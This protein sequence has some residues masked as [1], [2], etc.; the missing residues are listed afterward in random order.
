MFYKKYF[1]EPEPCNKKNDAENEGKD[2]LANRNH[3]IFNRKLENGDQFFKLNALHNIPLQTTY[4]GLLI[5]SGYTHEF[6]FHE[7]EDKKEAFKIGFFFDHITGLP[8][9]PGHSVKGVLRS[10]FPNHEKEKY[11]K[12]KSELLVELFKNMGLDPQQKFDAYLRG[13]N[14]NNYQ[15]EPIKFA[16]LLGEIIFEG[17]EPT[18][19]KDNN[20]QFESMALVHKDIFYDAYFN[21]K[22]IPFLAEDYITHHENPFKNPNPKFLK[23]LPYIDI[24]F[25][26]HLK[27]NLLTGDEKEKLFRSI[28]LLLGVGA[29]TN[30]G[31]GRLIDPQ[32][33]GLKNTAPIIEQ[34]NIGIK[35]E[36]LQVDDVLDAKKLLASQVEYR[37]IY[38]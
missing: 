21:S 4:P 18:R 11:V 1:L 6:D 33:G 20:L 34:I 37:S 9:I 12:E 13:K 36:K 17:N 31:Y 10:A 8:C 15:Y 16:Q 2:T 29:K 19:I 35:K 7:E 27:D 5:G 22:G 23:V 32:D 30:V 14:I 25:Q 24:Q 38:A 28:L 26:F 3:T